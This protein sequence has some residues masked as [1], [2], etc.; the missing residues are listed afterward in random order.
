MRWVPDILIIVGVMIFV[1]GIY[2][3]FG[4][5]YSLMTA[6]LS[7]AGLAINM[8][9]LINAANSETKTRNT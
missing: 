3:E 9:R 4:V 6:G 1:Y 2:L 8:A 5:A 7:M